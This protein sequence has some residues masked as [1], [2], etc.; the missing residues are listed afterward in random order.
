META[1]DHVERK[2]SLGKTAL[3]HH[4]N[5]LLWGGRGTLK[6]HSERYLTKN[7]KNISKIK[8]FMRIG[9]VKVTLTVCTVAFHW[10]L[11]L[12]GSTF[13]M[14]KLYFRH[15]AVSSAKTLNL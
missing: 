15:G 2:D 3:G 12:K 1:L 13:A 9:C 7:S 5:V 8:I 14:P 6:G 11:V 10:I 4:A